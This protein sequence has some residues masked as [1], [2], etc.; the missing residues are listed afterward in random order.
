MAKISSPFFRQKRSIP[1]EAALA[2]AEAA[3]AAS[4]AAVHDTEMSG[5][6]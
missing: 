6:S 2:A 3:D 5:V 1:D 4:R